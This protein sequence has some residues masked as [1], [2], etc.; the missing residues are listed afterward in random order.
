VTGFRI[1]HA[2]CLAAVGCLLLAALAAG[3]Q[4]GRGGTAAKSSGPPPVPGARDEWT[5]FRAPTAIAFDGRGNMYVANWSGGT[6]SRVDAAGRTSVFAE[7]A[8]S[9]AGLACDG[10]DNVYVSDYRENIYRI[11]ADGSKTV[12]ATGL[13]TPTGICFAR[14]GD[15]L[16]T[17]RASDELVRVSRTGAGAA[18][19]VAGGL[20]TPVGVAEHADGSIYVTNY[21]GGIT[22][23]APDGRV[24]ELGAEFAR[25]GCG[26]AVFRGEVLA[27]DNGDGTVK[28]VGA[29]GK[30]RVV[31]RDLSQPVALAVD[32]QGRLFV[33]TWGDGTVRRLE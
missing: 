5:G 4:T 16:V 11:G 25:P 15:L 1:G 28:S 6:V 26:I 21:G 13:R 3:C 31:A 29:D 14:N 22:R 9:P 24:A 33:G 32:G 8:G 2:A 12:F 18:T 19:V 10:A 23:I 20:R 7:V 27:V 17:N 30:A